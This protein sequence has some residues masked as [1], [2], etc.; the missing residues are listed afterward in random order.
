MSNHITEEEFLEASYIYLRKRIHI[1]PQIALVL[2]SGLGE[3]FPDFQLIDSI[4]YD[5]IP[6]FPIATVNEHK[7]R[8]LVGLI[9]QVPIILMQGRVHYYEGYSMNEVIRPIRL[10]KMLGANIL[11]LTNS[12]GSINSDYK[13]G[14]LVLIQDH[15]ASFVPNPLR[16]MNI[17]SI[18]T[19]FPD[20]S[21][22]YS[23]RLGNIV[24]EAAECMSI[25]LRKGVYL[26]TAGP[27]FESPAEIRMYGRMGADIVGM[28]TACE[29][30]AARHMGMEVVG[31]SC[32]SNMAS[33]ISKRE[34]SME[35]VVEITNRVKAKFAGFLHACVKQI[36][37]EEKQN[38]DK[39][40]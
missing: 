30:I 29:A 3:C 33:G 16:G 24:V 22:I 12:S 9:H 1:I 37:V 40:I 17:K 14:D 20:M 25:A 11:F 4:S 19:R 15:I 2:G 27:S 28:S 32:V 35:E 31:I 23:K 34:L 8:Y 21:T 7:G 6:Y 10:M 26:Q 38:E 39:I 18:G 13:P 5:E 36:I